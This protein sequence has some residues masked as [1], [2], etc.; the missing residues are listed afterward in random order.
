MFMD[1][2]EVLTCCDDSGSYVE[3]RFDDRLSSMRMLRE[4]KDEDFV[5][6][7]IRVTV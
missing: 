7:L 6:E 3:S 1:I 5:K 4:I 2:M